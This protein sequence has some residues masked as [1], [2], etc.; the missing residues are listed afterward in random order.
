[1]RNACNNSSPKEGKELCWVTIHS[2]ASLPSLDLVTKFQSIF[3][4]IIHRVLLVSMPKPTQ[5]A[6]FQSSGI[7][8]CPL[9]RFG[10]RLWSPSSLPSIWLLSLW[11]AR[12]WYGMNLRQGC[13][14]ETNAVGSNASEAA[15]DSGTA[16]TTP[17]CSPD[18][19]TQIRIPS[20]LQVPFV[21]HLLSFFL[22]CSSFPVLANAFH[23]LLSLSANKTKGAFCWFILVAWIK[24][25]LNLTS[26]DKHLFIC[27]TTESTPDTFHA[28]FNKSSAVL[29]SCFTLRVSF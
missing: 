12:Q 29:L 27:N 24:S 11:T 2:L 8:T 14:W 21:M 9:Q 19:H 10:S 22:C 17:K 13:T 18:T 6:G 15:T 7:P 25:K 23:L 20:G 4:F 3:T 5:F 1:M 16:T 28:S 26:L